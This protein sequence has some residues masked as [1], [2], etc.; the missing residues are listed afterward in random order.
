MQETLYDEL[1]QKARHGPAGIPPAQR[2][3]QRRCNGD[4][5]GW[6]GVGIAECLEALVPHWQRA[7]RRR[8]VQC[9]RMTACAA[10][11]AS[12]RAGMAAA[13]PRCPTR[14]P[15]DRPSPDG[16]GAAPGRG[17]HR[18]G[19]QHGHRADRGRRARPAA[20]RDSIWSAPTRRSRPMPARPRP[21]ARPS[22]PARRRRR[23]RK[24][25]AKRSA[26]A[27]VS[28]AATLALTPGRLSS[29]TAKR[30][31]H[32]PRRCRRRRTA[33][34]SRPPRD[35]RSAD[36]PARRQGAGQPLRRLRLRRAD[37]RTRGRPEARHGEAGEDHRRA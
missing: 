26:R 9:E 19:L 32:R 36:R 22:S 34:S 23:R 29:A 28:D 6:S 17:R 16:G 37:R 24:R 2:A 5:P 7:G 12:P 31:Q 8:G 21:R 13:T 30:A 15:S 33:T 20:R 1:A 11:S 4:R 35:L 14:R 25:C 3:A 27:N 18:P 10:A